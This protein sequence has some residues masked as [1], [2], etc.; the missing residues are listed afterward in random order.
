[1]RARAIGQRHRTARFSPTHR[2]A[3]GHIGQSIHKPCLQP[4]DSCRQPSDSAAIG[5]DWAVYIQPVVVSGRFPTP[6]RTTK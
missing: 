2:T 1:M 3:I 4:S 6:E 5:H